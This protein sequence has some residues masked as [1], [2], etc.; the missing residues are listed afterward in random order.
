MTFAARTGKTSLHE[1]GSVPQRV[2]TRTTC[3]VSVRSFRS[4]P[5]VILSLRPLQT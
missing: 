2:G 4:S 5:G 3:K 1:D